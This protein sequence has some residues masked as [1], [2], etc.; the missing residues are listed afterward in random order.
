VMWGAERARCDER[1]VGG[2][3]A[4]EGVDLRALEPGGSTPT[5]AGPAC[6]TGL[7]L[8]LAAP[9]FPGSPPGPR[10]CETASGSGGRRGPKAPTAGSPSAVALSV[11]VYRTVLADLPGFHRPVREEGPPLFREPL[12]LDL[13][14]LHHPLP[15]R[16]RGFALEWLPPQPPRAR[17]AWPSCGRGPWQEA[18]AEK[19]ARRKEEKQR[20][21]SKSRNKLFCQ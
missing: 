14:R 6:D 10:S 3:Q 4:G 2:Q 12:L 8:P 15:D 1:R 20:H 16:R 19:F 7:P 13:P 5:T 11:P 17:R 18:L 21:I 9:R